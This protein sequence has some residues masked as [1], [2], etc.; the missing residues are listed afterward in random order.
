MPAILLVGLDA[1]FT[2]V[3]QL[4]ILARQT[5]IVGGGVASKRRGVLA[6]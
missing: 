3:E 6:S 2:S 5:V 1:F 4:D